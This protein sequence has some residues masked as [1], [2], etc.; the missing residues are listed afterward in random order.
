MAINAGFLPLHLP[1]K[2]LCLNVYFPSFT[3]SKILKMGVFFKPLLPWAFFI[4]FFFLLKLLTALAIAAM[5]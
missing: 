2:C 5:K 1:L 3:F 4:I